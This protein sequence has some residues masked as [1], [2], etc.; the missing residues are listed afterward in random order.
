MSDTQYDEQKAAFL[1]F[2]S[3]IY[4]V[5]SDKIFACEFDFRLCATPKS[6]VVLSGIVS[7]GSILRKSWVQISMEN[8]TVP[9]T[10]VA[11]A[12]T[13][14]LMMNHQKGI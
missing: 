13:D 3:I 1:R 8:L 11:D 7:L 2:L 4:Q 10:T 14:S 6:W 5:T 12:T 9:D